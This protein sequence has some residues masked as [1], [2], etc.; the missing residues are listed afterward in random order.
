MHKK[1]K[2]LLII[3]GDQLF[4]SCEVEIES[5]TLV[6]M[7]EDFELA[8]RYK[9]HKHKIIFFF[10]A[11]RSYCNELRKAENSVVYW[12][13]HH[14]SFQKPFFKK[15]EDILGIYPAIETIEHFQV[16]DS[17]FER[18]LIDFCIKQKIHRIERQNP[19]FL[20][21]R[22]EFKAYL[23][24]SKKPLMNNFYIQ[25]RRRLNI[26]VDQDEKP[27]YGQWS[28]DSEN[29]KKYPKNIVFP[30][31]FESQSDVILMDVK[32][33]V[34]NFFN[35]HPGKS[36]DFWLVYTRE[37]ALRQLDHFIDYKIDGFGPYQD[38]IDSLEP[39]GFHSLLSPSI[40]AG[41][42]LPSEVITRILKKVKI[43]ESNRSSI[44]GFIRQIIGWREFVK[45]IYDN[46]QDE[47]DQRN[48]W[49]H[50]R[51]I[52]T[53]WYKGETGI[54]PFDDSVKR[55]IQ[56][57]YSHHID[58]L[59]VQSNLFLLSEIEPK[60]VYQWFMDFYVDS[61]DWVMAANVYG[62][63]LM[64]EGGLFATKPY[65]CGSNYILKM[66]HYKKEPWCD[67]LDGLYWR[68]IDKHRSFFLS[69]PRL[70]M[71]V[72]TLDK[73]ENSRRKTIFH[74]AELF[75]EQHTE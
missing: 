33:D 6:F 23:S 4:N 44:E 35:D 22:N 48:Y 56:Y 58:R 64:S 10:A 40:N 30:I 29:R 19:Q 69:N 1:Y 72:K 18:G 63:G 59:M 39:F 11:M 15:V 75:L 7:A 5:D 38:A 26:W 12:D 42:L 68:F 46:F 60:I 67:T 73:I 70:G 16:S 27:R 24:E 9:Y 53:S 61:A 50:F 49:Q 17:F 54:R 13:C 43:T 21:T 34:D 36:S 74:C 20:T 45:G 2:R 65:I 32:K 57:G 62:M 66:S 28:F 71:M 51:R 8:T 14:P 55:L 41:L 25:Q 52:K 31:S 3:L 37:Q 47:M